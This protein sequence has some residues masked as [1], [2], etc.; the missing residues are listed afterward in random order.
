MNLNRLALAMLLVLPALPGC[1]GPTPAATEPAPEVAT[2][3][4]TA[5]AAAAIPVSGQPAAADTGPAT[6]ATA[7]VLVTAT[8]MSEIFGR[9]LQAEAHE[10]S[11]DKT[12]CIY[13]PADGVSPYIELTV[14]W[15][16]GETAMRAMGAMAN[17]EPGIA[18]PYAGIGDQAAAVGTALMIRTGD[19]F[20]TITF[21]GVDDAPAKARKIFDTAKAKM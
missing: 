11:V 4:S 8:E 2:A 16:E 13:K 14:E 18:N 1:S 21:S 12:E 9:A 3:A 20:V 10:G 5:M 7:C 6:K 17:V 15:G 19:D